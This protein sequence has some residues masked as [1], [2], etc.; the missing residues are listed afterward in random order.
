ME[1][2]TTDQ[3]GKRNRKLLVFTTFKDTAEYLYENLSGL[4]AELELNTAMVSGDGTTTNF[5]ENNFNAVLTNFA[6]VARK[7]GSDDEA[8]EI[9]LLIATDCISEGQNLQDC[10]TVLNYDIHWNPVRLIQRFGRIDRIGSRSSVVHMVNYWPTA[11]MDAY[12]R[13][14]N[15]VQARM[16]LADVAASGDEDPFAEEEAQQELKFRDEQLMKLRQ[17]IL[18][19][20]EL[21]DTVVMS[22]FTLDHFLTQLLRYLERNR[23]ELEATPVGAYAITDGG[24]NPTGNVPPGVIVVLRQRNASIDRRQQPAS[25]FHPY[26]MV[27][28][29]HDG[30]IRYGC[31]NAR[32]VLGAFEEASAGRSDPLMHLCDW[33]DH[34][35]DH[36]K[37]MDHYEG[38]LTKIIAHIRQSH[39]AAQI[40]GLGGGGRRD[41]KLPKASETPRNERD[42]ELVTW[43][44][45]PSVPRSGATTTP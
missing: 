41:F 45:I 34:E 21:S 36:G 33:F 1:N 44:V 30:T 12:L 35:T 8:G 14:E 9:D 25:P 24:A 17:E 3:D 26:Y 31:A 38:L 32:R 6:P 13:L 19:L 2:P 29:R 5:G 28:I 42:F 39:N 15:R 22:D 18:D 37:K 40:R 10:D 23:E 4:A 20:D 27:Y 43:L 11:D 7:R 16:A